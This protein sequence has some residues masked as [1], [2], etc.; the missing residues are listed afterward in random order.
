MKRED[1]IVACALAEMAY[2]CLAVT[3]LLSSPAI[4]PGGG[5]GRGT[6]KAWDTD[7]LRYASGRYSARSFNVPF[8]RYGGYSEGA[9]QSG[10]ADAFFQ[11]RSLDGEMILKQQKSPSSKPQ[12]IAC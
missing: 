8:H 1:L 3:F 4:S 11:A 2:W 6:P 12:Q 10:V 7:N 5:R 9:C